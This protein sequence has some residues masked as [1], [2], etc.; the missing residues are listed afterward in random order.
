MGLISPADK[1]DDLEELYDILSFY[2]GDVKVVVK[3]QG[4]NKSLKYSVRNCR[5]L[6]SEICS[7][8]PEENIK[9]FEV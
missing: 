3:I 4:K 2:P 1:E 9:F 8:L 5:G 7:I 6:I